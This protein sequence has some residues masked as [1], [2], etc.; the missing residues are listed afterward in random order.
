MQFFSVFAPYS[1]RI[2]EIVRGRFPTFKMLPTGMVMTGYKVSDRMWKVTLNVVQ[3]YSFT[4]I[5]NNALFKSEVNEFLILVISLSY[6][7]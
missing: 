2:L 6:L 5:V 7:F 4:N 1:V 3:C